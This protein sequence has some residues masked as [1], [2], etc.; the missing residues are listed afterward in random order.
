M[1]K[2]R[3]NARLDEQRAGQGLEA[4]PCRT[5]ARVAQQAQ[6]KLQDQQLIWQVEEAS[7]DSEGGGKER[8]DSGT[9]Y[10]QLTTFISYGLDIY[11]AHVRQAHTESPLTDEGVQA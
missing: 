7:P 6:P 4:A 8:W 10:T 9:I 5:L 3:S 2:H 11:D 1:Q